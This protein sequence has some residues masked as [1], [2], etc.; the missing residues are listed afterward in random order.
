MN[1][2]IPVSAPRQVTRH[3]ADFP[4]RATYHGQL[5]NPRCT[6]LFVHGMVEGE[7]VWAPVLP[8]IGLEEQVITLEMP[9]S[10]KYGGL[11]GLKMPPEEWLRLALK[12][13]EIKP[14][15][16]AG[17]SFGA[18]SCLQYLDKYPQQQLR[19]LLL[20]SPFFKEKI[21]QVTW[22]L[23][24][25]YVNEFERFIALSISLR[26][27]SRKLSDE[28]FAIILQKLRDQF[29]CY[30]WVQFWQ[31]FERTPLLRL[32]QLTMPCLIITGAEDFS[33]AADDVAVL[34]GLLPDAHLVVH[35]DCSHFCLTTR[36]AETV[37]LMT[38]F[39]QQHSQ[40]QTSLTLQQN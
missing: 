40:A 5:H 37:Q 35:P 32:Q 9:W 39:M 4:I 23:F 3:V 16:I 31:L 1:S 30:S 38:E 27:T 11:W 28:M 8:H 12:V 7:E 13:H 29:G 19:A 33:S 36:E 34:A 24:H 18:N 26:Q 25:R 15:A 22:S 17:H 21:E 2:Q 10:G 14:D 20:I 6:W